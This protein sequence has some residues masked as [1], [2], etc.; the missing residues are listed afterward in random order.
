MRVRGVIRRCGCQCPEPDIAHQGVSS[1]TILH[2][3]IAAPCSCVALSFQLLANKVRP[4]G[5]KALGRWTA[6]LLAQVT[7]AGHY[8]IAKELDAALRPHKQWQHPNAWADDLV[9]AHMVRRGLDLAP[10]GLC[11]LEDDD[12]VL[13]IG[14][15]A[16]AKGDTPF[17][18]LGPELRAERSVGHA[19]KLGHAVTI[20]DE[21]VL[22]AAD[23]RHDGG[24]IGSTCD[25]SNDL[26]A[27]VVEVHV[28]I[29]PSAMTAYDPQGRSG[30]DDKTTGEDRHSHVHGQ[31]NATTPN[32][33]PLQFEGHL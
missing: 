9:E 17:V 6:F 10:L 27:G 2:H 28:A 8:R 26:H 1:T 15:Q 3:A 33:A 13:G 22:D 25:A 16:G 32:E 20:H 18:A 11:G 4:G 14:I 29:W 21:N 30:G 7:V 31:A 19:A 23:F 5:C 24:S 12:V